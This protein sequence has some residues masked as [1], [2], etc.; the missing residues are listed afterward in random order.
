MCTLKVKAGNYF[1]TKNSI[2]AS[3]HL[4]IRRDK[5]RSEWKLYSKEWSAKGE[6]AGDMEG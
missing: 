6:I 5:E 3:S 1:S 4:E 2:K